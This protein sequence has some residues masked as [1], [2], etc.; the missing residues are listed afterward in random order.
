[1]IQQKRDQQ[2]AQM[3]KWLEET[4]SS[5]PL[6]LFKNMSAKNNQLYNDVPKYDK[7]R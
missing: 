3:K 7:K 1:M 4:N 6:N 2:G 5:N